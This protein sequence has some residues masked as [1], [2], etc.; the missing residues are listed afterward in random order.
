MIV[1][2]MRQQLTNAGFRFSMEPFA[3]TMTERKQG[4]ERIYPEARKNQAN[5]VLAD[6]FK[7]LQAQD[8]GFAHFM[9]AREKKVA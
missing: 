7:E 3:E 4:P 1:D 5:T 6:K 2:K 9:A 8:R